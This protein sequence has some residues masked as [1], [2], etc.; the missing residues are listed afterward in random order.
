MLRG[1]FPRLQENLWL[2]GLPGAIGSRGGRLPCWG[3]GCRWGMGSQGM[4]AAS[5][6][7]V[8][9]C[10]LRPLALRQLG[11]RPLL[12]P[13]FCGSSLFSSYNEVQGGCVLAAAPGNAEVLKASPPG[14]CSLRP[15]PLPRPPLPQAACGSH[16]PER[17]PPGASPRQP[18]TK[19]KAGVLG[20]CEGGKENPAAEA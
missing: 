19:A 20:W 12:P 2:P 16:L 9:S 15:R 11:P 18:G 7:G 1:T 13:G 17:L 4:T 8:S 6:G 14:G 3:G 10:H 5:A